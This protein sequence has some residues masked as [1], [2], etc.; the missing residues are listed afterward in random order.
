MSEEL[1][2]IRSMT[3]STKQGEPWDRGCSINFENLTHKELDQLTHALKFGCGW[4]RFNEGRLEIRER[5]EE[6]P[7][8]ESDPTMVGFWT[9]KPPPKEIRLPDPGEPHAP[10]VFDFS[11]IHAYSYPG[12]LIQ[13]LCGYNY[14]RENYAFQVKQVESF[15]FHCL[16]SRRNVGQF[17]EAWLLPSLLFAKGRLKKV[18]EAH[19]AC[20]NCG[21]DD[22]AS[23]NFREPVEE[24]GEIRCMRC[25]APRAFARK[26]GEAKE[27]KDQLQRAVAFLQHTASFGTLDVVCQR[28]AM[29]MD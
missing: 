25:V 24:G 28:L 4:V 21:N 16:R 5:Y 15:G 12:I 3:Y 17:W 27:Q 18:I 22:I 13:H 29:V 26:V 1:K 20:S 2:P 10:T 7:A 19:L 23:W 8:P 9:P 14:S 6:M 11:E